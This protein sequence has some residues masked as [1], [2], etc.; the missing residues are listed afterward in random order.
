MNAPVTATKLT[1]AEAARAAGVSRT[2]VWRAIKQG[3]LSAEPGEDGGIRIDASELL[4]VFPHADLTRA[5]ERSGDGALN[6]HE[7]SGEH[8]ATGELSA[9]RAHIEELKDDKQ[10][11]RT[12]LER[13]TAERTQLLEMLREKDRLLSDQAEHVRLLTHQGQRTRG[14]FARWRRRET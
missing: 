10:H 9:L 2:S 6:V 12:E 8:D 7:R 11:L 1:Q 3:R 4:R 13:A 14:W 5:H